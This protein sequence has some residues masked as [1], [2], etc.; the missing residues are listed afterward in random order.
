MDKRI[1]KWLLDIYETIKSIESYFEDE[2]KDFSLYVKNEMRKKAVERN[3]E[4]I[5]EAV[6]RILNQDP[7]FTKKISDARP[8]VDLRNYIIHSYDS[9]SDENIWSILI[10]HLPKL[11]TE[12]EALLNENL[13]K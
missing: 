3:L 2:P 13:Q 10:T 11:K 12:V 9:V 7:T 1:E 4:I 8:I 6:N 5:G